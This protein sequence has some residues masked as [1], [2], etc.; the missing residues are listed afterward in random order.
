L[1]YFIFFIIIDYHRVILH[2]Q[3]EAAVSGPHLAP[4]QQGAVKHLMLDAA[5]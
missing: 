4:L 3:P 5:T 1:Q 2:T